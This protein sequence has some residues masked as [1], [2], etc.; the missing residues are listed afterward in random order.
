MTPN[1]LRI[2]CLFSSILAILTG[3]VSTEELVRED[4][5]PLEPYNR[6]MF[7]FNDTV[8]KA[9]I[10]PLAKGY[11]AVLPEFIRNRV[12][13]FFNNLNEVDA[14]IN[15][16]LQLKGEQTL[17][18]T[19]RFVYNTV[20]GLGGLF[21]VAGTFGLPRHNQDFGQTLARWGVGEGYYLVVPIYGPSTTR[22][23]WGIPVDRIALDPVQ[24]LDPIAANLGTRA[25][26]FIDFRANLL[27]VERAFEEAQIDP[28]SFQRQTYLQL[29]RNLI[30]EGHPP[31][32]K[33]EL[34]DSETPPAK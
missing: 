25:V 21:D 2:V 9:L 19:S 13:Y 18:D 1:K 30:Y 11:Q 27:R 7:K 29:R 3:C 23:V 22:D 8:D 15:D 26:R 16:L 5:D 17:T 33:L 34:E 28:Y 14:V 32:P 20:F 24:Y 6:A 12:T 10:K 31:R 4:R